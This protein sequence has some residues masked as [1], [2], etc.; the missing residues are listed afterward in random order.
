[1]RVLLQRVSR[2]EVRVHNQITGK[3]GRGL[4]VFVGIGPND[5]DSQISWMV[6]KIKNLRIFDDESGR[7]NHSLE[8]LA[9]ETDPISHTPKG[10]ALLVSQFTLYGECKKGRRPDFSGAAPVAQARE[11]YERFVEH[12][13]AT[14]IGVQTGI[15]Q[16]M[17]EVDLVNDGPVTLWIESP[18]LAQELSRVV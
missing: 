1:M 13:R 10:Q 9:R 5:G 6:E 11:V 14:G 7:L 17:M 8:D 15:F 18:P 3:I 16:A 2:A 4:V 12:F